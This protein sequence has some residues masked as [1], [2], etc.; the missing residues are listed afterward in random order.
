MRHLFGLFVLLAVGMLQA[1]GGGSNRDALTAASAAAAAAAAGASTTP[2]SLFTTAP[3]SIVFLA[4]GP[5]G[6][7]E[8]GGGKPPYAASTSNAAV[9]T[10]A[11]SGTSLTIAPHALGVATLLLLDSVGAKME[12]SVSVGSSTQVAP[13]RTTA[14]SAVGLSVGSAA[15]YLISGGV[16]PYV[17]SS[18]NT[19]AVVSGV[20]GAT[21][22]VAAQQT[23][24]TAQVLVI[25]A[26]GTQVAIAVTV[27]SATVEPLFTSAPSSITMSSGAGP[28]S[29][30]VGGGFPPYVAS[31]SNPGVASASVS[32]NTLSVSGGAVG[33]ASVVVT[34]AVG[35]RVEFGVSVGAA[36]PVAT[37]RTDAPSALTLTAGNA[38]SFTVAGGQGAYVAH[39]A[40]EGVATARIAGASLTITAAGSG[41]TQVSVQDAAG[42]Q[43]VIAVTVGAATVQPLFTSA[44]S[45]ITL[46]SGVGPSSFTVGGGVLPYSASSSNPGVAS[47]SV[48]GNA[49]SV[50]GMA[51]GSAS[52]VVTDAV[53]NRVD[54]GVNVGSTTPVTALRTD[55]PS[56]LTLSAGNSRTYAVAGG[57][58][59]YTANS[60]NEGVATARIASG[61]LTIT[62][63]GSGSTQVLV[64]DAA[65]NQVV[66][67][68]TVGGPTPAALFL[69]TPAAVTI[70]T[71]AVPASYAIGGGTPP[72]TV[73]T[74][75]AAVASATVSGASLTVAGVRQGNATVTVFDAAGAQA[76]V[77]VT[78]SPSTGATLSV[79]PAGASGNVGDTLNFVL[80]GGSPGYTLTSSNANVATLSTSTVAASGG[81]FSA[82]LLNSGE[83]IVTVRDAL[84]QITS[85]GVSVGAASPQLRLSP[86]A[87]LVGENESGAISLNIYGGT[88]PYRALSSD[89]VKASVGTYGSVLVTSPGTSLN[90]C[91]DPVTD[92]TPPVYVLGGTYAV[93]LT[94]MDSQGASATSVMTLKDNGA[95]LGL[96]CP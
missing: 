49:L 25:D 59:A 2:A 52:V 31:S 67:A 18:S 4:G 26:A 66:I 69:A 74:S 24:G 61:S 80:H 23:A 77:S 21:L 44:P 15:S 73:Q 47:V 89:L 3:G 42:N 41:S 83:A 40:N 45:S 72:Y 50:S 27:G 91:I 76:S 46:S 70:P 10:V 11:V 35:T 14:A 13:L 5:V 93:T 75:D 17:S 20:S 1:C 54:F 65:G 16:A 53:G 9:A 37:L 86:N 60:A 78:V 19:A 95:G 33:S 55:A 92:A 34:D 32:A 58:G 39:S 82:N 63:A 96:G 81:G 79:L 8:M 84:G 94:V 90:R 36:T 64:Q 6:S 68:V 30:T 22:T 43:V 12:I 85:F 88:P 62:A 71:G 48:S 29:F 7:Y 51:V 56:A 38:R 28:S 87:F 57:Q